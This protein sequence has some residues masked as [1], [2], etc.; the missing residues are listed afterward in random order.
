[1]AGVTKLR[2]VQLGKENSGTPG[3]E[4]NATAIWRGTGV[5]TDETEVQFVE[6]NVGYL[7][8]TDR[9]MITKVGGVLELDDTPATFEQLP[10]LLDAGVDSVAG[11]KDGDGS[12]YVY[13]YTFPKVASDTATPA[14]YTVE[15]GDNQQEEQFLYGFVEAF[16]LS[17]AAG[18]ALNMS[19]TF[20][21]RQVATG[22]KTAAL[23]LPAVEEINFSSGK[24]YIDAADTAFGTT[25]KS[26]TL[27]EATLEVDTGLRAVHTADGNLYFSFT[28]NIGAEITLDITFEH[29]ATS[30]AEKAAWRAETARKIRLIFE[31]SALTQGTAYSKKTLVIDLVGKWESF[32]SLGDNDGNDTVTG[33]F[34]ARYNSTATAF[35]QIVVVNDLTALT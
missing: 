12:G 7:S 24:L 18:D 4:V 2:F 29:D 19:G 6:E 35:A 9:T 22:T 16:T 32:E 11:V 3:T 15:A 5:V 17:G 33:T 10:Y 30:V 34:R 1:M 13:T 14:T 31:G 8:G 28:K 25:L 21:G 26:N 20:R 27:L 23:S